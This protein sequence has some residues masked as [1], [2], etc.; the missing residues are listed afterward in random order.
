MIR[1]KFNSEYSEHDK[2]TASK[3]GAV[4]NADRVICISENKKDVVDYFRVEEEKI[5]VVY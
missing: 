3:Y 4:Q 1:E 2:T 5:P